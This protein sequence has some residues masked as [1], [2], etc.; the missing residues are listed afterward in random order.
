MSNFLDNNGICFFKQEFQHKEYIISHLLSASEKALCFVQGKCRASRGG[1]QSKKCAIWC[2]KVFK[3][4]VLVTLHD[5]I[6]EETK[7]H[8]IK[9]HYPLK[10]GFLNLG[11]V[12]IW[13]KQLFVVRVLSCASQGVQPHPWP[14]PMRCQE[15]SQSPDNQKCFQTLP[16]VSWG[17]KLSPSL[18]RSRTTSVRIRQCSKNS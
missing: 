15:H 9:P 7:A 4:C 11:T 1:S 16:G 8:L 12:D 2:A 5:F 14:L 13:T 18:P 3:C 6:G 10:A 17:V